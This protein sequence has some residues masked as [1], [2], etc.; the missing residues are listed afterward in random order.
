[1]P[2]VC[3]MGVG[4]GFQTTRS[5]PEIQSLIVKDMEDD[6]INTLQRARRTN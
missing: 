2:K 3:A 4:N 1:M 6:S 5:H